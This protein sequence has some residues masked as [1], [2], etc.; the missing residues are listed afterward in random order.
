[1]GVKT[2][3]SV[4]RRKVVLQTISNSRSVS[5]VIA[6]VAEGRTLESG[7]RNRLEASLWLNRPVLFDGYR[8][9]S[10]P[11]LFVSIIPNTSPF[12]PLRMTHRGVSKWIHPCSS[13]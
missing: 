12:F 13:W 2:A 4:T 5:T 10:I 11:E 6:V 3:R 9:F 8:P 7:L 1:M